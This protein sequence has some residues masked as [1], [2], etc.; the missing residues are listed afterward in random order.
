MLA[1]TPLAPTR[2][3]GYAYSDLASHPLAVL[4]PYSMHSY[5]LV[6]VYALG[7][8]ILAPSLALL[9]ELHA[10]LGICNH[11]GGGNVP[12]RRSKERERVPYDTWAWLLHTKHFWFS[13]PVAEGGPCCAHDPNDSCDA[14]AASRWLQFADWYQWPNVTYFSTP[15]ELL[16]Q[17][18][19][20]MRDAARR[21]AISREMKVW[22]LVD[23][24]L[25]PYSASTS[26]THPPRS[27]P[28][29]SLRHTHLDPVY[30]HLPRTL[31]IAHS[32]H[33]HLLFPGRRSSNG[34]ACVR[35]DMSVTPSCAR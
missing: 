24:G 32:P 9:S 11:K 5:G 31:L 6:Q 2:K 14:T 3:C 26:F 20:L 25:L 18:A 35:S 29:L 1:N 16:S 13:P 4:L 7:V 30:F 19:L 10:T 33:S 15:E 8:P 34:S 27:N 17:A 22:Y 23:A 28:L 21:H 12:W